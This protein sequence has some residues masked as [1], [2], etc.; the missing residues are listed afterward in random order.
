MSDAF[1]KNLSRVVKALKKL[2][3]SDD[4]KCAV[5]KAKTYR[6]ACVILRH[7][8][9]ISPASFHNKGCA[10]AE[11]MREVQLEVIPEEKAIEE[12]RRLAFAKEFWE[13]LNN[14]K[15][16]QKKIR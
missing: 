9:W 8:Y 15:T 10:L 13:K 12:E 5:C 14:D 16:T 7:G 3:V 4:G 1:G 6:D 2:E 11:V